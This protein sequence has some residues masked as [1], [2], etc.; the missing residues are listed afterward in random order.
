MR[1]LIEY[2]KDFVFLITHPNYY[3]MN[4]KYNKEYDESFN[5]LLNEYEFS[6]YDG[7][8][9]NL[10]DIMLW[11]DNVPYSCFSLYTNDLVTSRLRPSRRSIHRGLKKLNEYL[12]NLEINK[13]K[14]LKL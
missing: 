8:T 9:V 11:V 7:Y 14:N 1:K 12:E 2:I 6:K 13:I 5:K 4:K 10:G 3:I